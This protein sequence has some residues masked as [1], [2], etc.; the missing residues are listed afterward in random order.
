MKMSSYEMIDNEVKKVEHG[1]KGQY[2]TNISVDLYYSLDSFSD[3][4]VERTL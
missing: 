2:Q 1:E 4:G 3:G